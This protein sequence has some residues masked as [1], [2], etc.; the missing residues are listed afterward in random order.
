[1]YPS[2]QVGRQANR[3]KGMQVGR[4]QAGR[5]QVTYTRWEPTTAGIPAANPNRGASPALPALCWCMGKDLC[6]TLPHPA[7][8]SCLP[9]PAHHPLV[10]RSCACTPGS[11]R[12]AG[13]TW[14]RAWCWR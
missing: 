1:V 8:H 4:H 11:S 3:K 9:F 14:G 12:W 5:M 6:S 10:S 13:G 2:Q 7:T